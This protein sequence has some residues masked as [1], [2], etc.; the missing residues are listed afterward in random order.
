MRDLLARLAQDD[1]GASSALRVLDYFDA[2]DERLAGPEAYLRGAVALSSQ[3]AGLSISARR[4]NI[5]IGASG[6]R[7]ALPPDFSTKLD[8][9]QA[10][11]PSTTPGRVWIEEDDP[12]VLHSLVL[13]RV[14]QGIGRWSSPID[15]LVTT[16][17]EAWRILLNDPVPYDRRAQLLAALRLDESRLYR[18]VARVPNVP[19][20]GVYA[21][22]TVDGVEVGVEIAR[23]D[24]PISR[25]DTKSRAGIGPATAVSDILRSWEGAST[26]LRMARL[27]EHLS[28]EEMGVLGPL[29]MHSQPHELLADPVVS[30]MAPGDMGWID[31]T[32]NAIAKAGSV[33]GAA[34]L[35]HLHHSTVQKRVDKLHQM[36]DVDLSIARHIHR[37]WLACVTYRFVSFGGTEPDTAPG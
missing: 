8:W 13:E 15:A 20:R 24:F 2:L 6:E 22:A 31:E 28:W 1:E 33:R 30:A 7:I 5:R 4:I 29:F 25:D 37:L 18:V 34:D 11:L 32:I 21:V 27:G 10:D 35:L 16:P 9:P 12:G 19:A 26:V 17:A 23:A 3:A 36:F 14:V